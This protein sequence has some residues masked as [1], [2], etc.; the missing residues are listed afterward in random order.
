MWV[1][2]AALGVS[3]EYNKFWTGVG[4]FGKHWTSNFDFKL[5]FGTASV[6]SCYPRPGGGTCGIGVNTI[7]YAHRPDART[8]K[9]IKNTTDGIFY[10]EKPSPVAKIVPQADGSFIL[11]GEDHDVERY[12]SAGYVST[13][14]NEYGIGW[15]YSYSG[16]YPVRVTH[17]SGRY[18]EFVWTSGQLT[19]VRD[20]AGNYHGYAYLADRF[21]T[22]LH[23]LSATAKPGS[24]ATSI[25]YHYEDTRF[26]GGLTGKSFSGVRYSWFTYDAAGRATSTE[27]GGGKDR[28]S[29]SYAGGD[30][31][32]LLVEE[33]NPLGK[34]TSYSFLDGKTQ[35]VQGHASTYCP[36]MSRLTTF[37][38]NGYDDIVRDFN[39]NA[40]DYDYNAKG[41]PIQA[42]TAWASQAASWARMVQPPTSP[43]M[44]K[45]ASH[46]RAATPMLARLIP[47]MSTMPAA[48]WSRSRPAM[49]RSR[50][51][52]TTRPID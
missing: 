1:E 40:I 28:Y 10:E 43:T 30:V 11:Y 14:H 25:A 34:Q 12:S 15:T 23:L 27:H 24:P 49:A 47:P 13:V 4:I 48:C 45:G 38:A 46:S 44:R 39:G 31:N 41:R 16:T 19:S 50:T 5:T 3:R 26:P 35:Y 21:G 51:M 7:I 6:N 32:E 52:N 2:E 36:A 8:I 22:G 42:T 20:P 29:F 33:T 9:F 17:T 37:D 18:V